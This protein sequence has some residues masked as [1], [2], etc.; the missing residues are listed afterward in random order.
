M[1]QF[2][3]FILAAMLM[4]SM[5]ACSEDEKAAEENNTA[6]NQE[7]IVTPETEEKEEAS[8]EETEEEEIAEEVDYSGELSD[9]LYQPDSDDETTLALMEIDA[10]EYGSAGASLKQTSS[11]VQVLNLSLQED[12][13]E[14][15]T[16]YLDGMTATQKDYF[17]FQWQM[18]VDKA[19]Q[20]LTAEDAAVQ[21]EEAGH[22]DLD[23]S[24]F[25][26]EALEAFNEMMTEALAEQGV[27][28]V[29]KEHTDFEP[30][31]HWAQA[32]LAEEVTSAL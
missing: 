18:A 6:S 19:E 25:D 12:I 16:A 14:A 11:A 17:S 2:T 28:D 3:A 7:T 13:S 21:L 22:G 4:L 20:L 10:C 29:W 1:K 30:F 5:A 27:T 26:A 24:Q 15:L 8:S 32:Q 31:A 9:W 23:L